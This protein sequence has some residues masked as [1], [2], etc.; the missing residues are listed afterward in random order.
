VPLLRDAGPSL[1]GLC[2]DDAGNAIITSTREVYRVRVG[3][4]PY[5][6]F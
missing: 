6:P 3:A 4:K 2:L 1:V 5:W